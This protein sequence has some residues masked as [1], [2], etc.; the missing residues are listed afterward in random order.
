VSVTAQMREVAAR[1]GCHG[2]FSFRP[3]AVAVQCLPYLSLMPSCGGSPS[4]EVASIP[5]ARLIGVMGGLD[6]TIQGSL[7]L[8]Y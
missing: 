3:G 7:L 8:L 2:S 6:A 1:A 4:G 5:F